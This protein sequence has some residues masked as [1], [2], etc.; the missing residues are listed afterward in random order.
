MCSGYDYCENCDDVFPD[1]ELYHNMC[2]SCQ[3]AEDNFAIG[4]GVCPGCM[5]RMPPCQMDEDG[6][7]ECCM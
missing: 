4:Q 5:K 1:D 6:E 3:N 7:Y 2:N